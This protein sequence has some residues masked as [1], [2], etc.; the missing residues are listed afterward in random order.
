MANR[1]VAKSILRQPAAVPT[2]T[3]S[4]EQKAKVERDRQN[5][6]IALHHANKIQAQKNFESLIVSNIE[7]L[8]DL[9]TS[10]PAT[11]ADR[12]TFVLRVTP[13]QP[14]DFASL[15]E[16]RTN[17]GKCGYAL[18]SQSPRSATV[19]QNATWKLKA[20]GA[21]DYCSNDCLRRALYVKTQLSEV[22]AWERQAG[23]QPLIRLYCDDLATSLEHDRSSNVVDSLRMVHD[24]D[25]ALERGESRG[26][27]RPG[28]VTTDTVVE[29]ASAAPGT[30]RASQASM[31]ISSAAI[32][33]Y[34]PAHN[35]ASFDTSH[36]RID[37]AN[38]GEGLVSVA[39]T[40]ENDSWH[41]LYEN[42]P[43]R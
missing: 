12:N 6:G 34:V 16:E 31:T 2:P 13:F 8:L 33:G 24:H 40:E 38:Y 9:P 37:A 36:D 7:A 3:L 42:L 43:K 10:V 23:Q 21:A 35:L 1:S 32:E 14:S 27:F 17:D 28:Q 39:A 19:G 22:P 29:R 4:D 15:V 30:D 18:C 5:L 41:A 25:L 26:S 20:Q 11:K